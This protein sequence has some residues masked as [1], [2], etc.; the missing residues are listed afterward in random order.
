MH[1]YGIHYIILL[2]ALL[3]ITSIPELGTAFT[4]HYIMIYY[5]T[6]TFNNIMTMAFDHRFGLRGRI[7]NIIIILYISYTR[8]RSRTRSRTY[9][10][11]LV[12]IC[13]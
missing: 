9:T 13:I 8:A 11:V 12:Y 1:L 3:L 7:Y 2:S 10:R 6:T 5:N 4:M